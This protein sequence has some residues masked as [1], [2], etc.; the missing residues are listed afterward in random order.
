MIVQIYEIQTPEEAEACIE[1]GVDH[2]GSVLFSKDDWRQPLLKKVIQLSKAAGVKNSII[3]LFHEENILHSV[4]D[5]YHPAYLHFCETLSTDTERKRDLEPMVKRQARLKEK[6][7]ETGM[8]RTI[9]IPGKA[10]VAHDLP[11]VDMA[12]AFERVT[13]F[14]LIDTWVERT[15]VEGFIGITG[16]TADWDMAKELVFNTDIPVIL[17]GGLSPENVHE[18]LLKVFPAGADSCTQTNRVDESGKAVRLKKDFEKV[19]KFVTE[20]RRAEETIRHEA[21]RLRLKLDELKEELRERETALPAHSVRPH[22]LLLIE[23]LEE[24]IARQEKKLARL[25]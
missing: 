20:V 9:P 15:P 6:F 21:E 1:A 22:Q 4:V 16:R 23:E 5:Y 18:A 2:I 24:E 25:R 8:I 7:P 12:R 13:D 10:S 14:F 19:K 3:P 11:F 17:A